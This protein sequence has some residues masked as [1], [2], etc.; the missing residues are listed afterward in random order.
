MAQT[1]RIG[2]MLLDTQL[3]ETLRVC[4]PRPAPQ[5]RPRS[6]PAICTPEALRR[7]IIRAP[8]ASPP[9][10]TRG[11]YR[12]R[13]GGGGALPC[14]SPG[15]HDIASGALAEYTHTSSPHSPSLR[16]HGRHHL[17]RRRAV[18]QRR[19]RA[20]TRELR[21][22]APHPPAIPPPPRAPR[23]S[24]FAGAK[25]AAT[26]S[27]VRR[28]AAPLANGASGDSARA[29]PLRP[30]ALVRHSRLRRAPGY[31]AE[32]P[33][34]PRFRPRTVWLT[35]SVTAATPTTRA[36][37][38]GLRWLGPS[39]APVRRAALQVS[40]GQAPC[41]RFSSARARAGPR[42]HAERLPRAAYEPPW[43]HRCVDVVEAHGRRT[44]TSGP[45]QRHAK[46]GARVSSVFPCFPPQAT[47]SARGGP[48]RNGAKD[49]AGESLW[50][51]H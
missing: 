13:G 50:N 7:A 26:C 45:G 18:R 19:Q 30:S 37:P 10:R 1:T 6:S 46:R 33:A 44:A 43:I 12:S 21:P 31:A 28:R 49:G 36:W 29:P 22:R 5:R 25:W 4:S 35:N 40:E 42:M 51:K 41:G 39:R 11:G 48:G 9:R 15:V 20:R 14:S 24:H 34:S 32:H 2:T 17:H 3:V 23:W 27:S 16:V 47:R 8:A 38:S